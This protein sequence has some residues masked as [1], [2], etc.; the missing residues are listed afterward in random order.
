MKSTIF[1]VSLLA[2]TAAHAGH[3]TDAAVPDNEQSLT[4][5]T[6][7][8]SFPAPRT[9]PEQTGFR[10]ARVASNGRF[11]GWL[12]LRPNCCTSY[13]LPTA[14]VILDE[15]HQLH[16]FE[17]GPLIWDWSLQRHNTAVAYRMRVAHGAAPV[18]YEL[19]RIRDAK[20]LGRYECSANE[21][22]TF[23]ARRSKTIPA[24]V[25]PIAEECPTRA[26]DSA[27]ADPKYRQELRGPG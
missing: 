6:A 12:A 26:P 23:L 15:R 17:G 9:E 2:A 5:S 8:H 16:R 18:I 19:R 27:M 3:F 1:L 11:V 25:W 7:G 10:S 24:W 4:I 14:L 21:L 20:L 13:P 22:D